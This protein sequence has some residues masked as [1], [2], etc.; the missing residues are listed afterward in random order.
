MEIRD[1]CDSM[2]EELSSQKAR[3]YDV[4]RVIDKMPVETR[5]R[6]RPQID[7]I[8]I[9]IG[10]LSRRIDRLMNE[11]PADW[12]KTKREIED[13]KA[14]LLEKINWW[15]ETHIGGGYLGG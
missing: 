5:A 10:D 15:D 14:Q 3:M 4:L 13:L 1:Y 11:C 6:I 9:L 8:H 7:E 2:Y 12:C